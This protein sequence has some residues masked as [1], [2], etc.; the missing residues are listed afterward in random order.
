[1]HVAGAARGQQQPAE[2]DPERRDDPL[3]ATGAES[4]VAADRGQGDGDDR[5]VEDD[6]E[7]RE[8]EQHERS[9]RVTAI[10][11][12][13]GHASHTALPGITLTVVIP[14][15]IA[16][17]DLR[18]GDLALDF[19]NTLE[20]TR[21]G[22]P[23]TEHLR[24]YADLAAWAVHAGL[25]PAADGEALLARAAGEGVA[26]GTA[27]QAAVD[28]RRV[29]HDVFAALADGEPAPADALRALRDAHG[30]ALV[31]AT[32]APGEHGT[33]RWTWAGDD[34][35]RPIWPVAVAAVDLLRHGP[36]ERLKACGQCVWLF[37]DQSRNRSRR[38]CSMSEC[39]AQVKMRRYRAAHRD[40]G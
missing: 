19:A 35:A 15:H 33:H 37:L 29:V 13:V 25:L 40:R 22:P 21:G 6:D 20:G 10:N 30:A 38:W 39:G 17:L 12:H 3:Q 24:E 7:L 2:G 16:E 23:G 31:R 8:A 9:A 14:P 27:L 18:G 11:A 28:L 1:V 4:E 34:L 26:A 32:L 36:L 5:D